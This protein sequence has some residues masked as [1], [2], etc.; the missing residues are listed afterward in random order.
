MK[1]ELSERMQAVSALVPKG[2]VAADI[3][4]DHGFVS[5]D[6]VQRSICPH[7]Y[8][9]DVRKGPLDRA[10][11][12][13]ASYGLEDKI[14]AV[15]S[16]GLKDVPVCGSGA[17]G[18]IAAGMG[19]KLIVSI[20]TAVPE[21][22]AQLSWCVLSPQSE[23]WLVRQELTEL[24]FFIIEENMVLEDGKYYPM[25]LAV[26]AGADWDVKVENAQRKKHRLA[27]KLLQSGLTEEMCRFAGDWLGWQ[28][29]PVLQELP[30]LI[31]LLMDSRSEVLFSFLEHT[32]KTDEALLLAMP[33]PDGDRAADC[34]DQ[35]MP[36]D[37]ATE[38][39]LK[40]RTELE[41]RIQLSEKVLEV[42]KMEK[43]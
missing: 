27:E 43:Q 3:G 37:D 8:A 25:M 15:L 40:R 23:I 21:K 33:K 10:K 42:L 2:H 38:R 31:W 19:G 22:T 18:F 9:A 16:D 7:V 4:C 24:D 32:I 12:H 29:Q 35:R 11:E 14:T 39:I 28:L 30:I 26:R 1:I 6:L 34:S 13:I 5:I 41:A 17:D 20:L 36:G